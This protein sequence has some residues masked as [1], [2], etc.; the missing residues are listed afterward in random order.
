LPTTE[1]ELIAIAAPAIMGLS[2]NPVKG[3]NKPAARGYKPFF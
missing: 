2:K 3:N 1:T